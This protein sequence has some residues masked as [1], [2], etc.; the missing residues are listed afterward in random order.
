[1]VLRIGHKTLFANKCFTTEY[2]DNPVTQ[3]YKEEISEK[4]GQIARKAAE[5]SDDG[6][7]SA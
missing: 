6:N 7:D 5:T 4:E 2:T 3:L 1:M